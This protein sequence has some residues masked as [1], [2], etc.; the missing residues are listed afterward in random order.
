MEKEKERTADVVRKIML[1]RSKKGYT[2]ENMANELDITTAAYRKIETGET[3]LSLERLFKIAE[4]LQE[5]V[6]GLIETAEGNVF[7][8][9]NNENSTCNQNQ[10]RQKI[11]NFYQENKEVYDK[12]LKSKDEQIELLKSLLR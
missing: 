12:L 9:T 3:K 1:L 6:A 7:N 4:I 5:S 8:Q 2:Y 11:E 10:Y